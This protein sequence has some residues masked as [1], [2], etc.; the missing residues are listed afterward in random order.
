MVILEAPLV[1]LH[2]NDL[3]DDERDAQCRTVALAE[4]EAF[5]AQFSVQSISKMMLCHLFKEGIPLDQVANELSMDFE[6][7]ALLYVLFVLGWNTNKTAL[8]DR[9]STTLIRPTRSLISWVSLARLSSST[10]SS[11]RSTTHSVPRPLRA[12]VVCLSRS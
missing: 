12:T 3:A 11:P 8:L 10:L 1:D 4:H 6:D 5:D 7:V 9:K 2:M